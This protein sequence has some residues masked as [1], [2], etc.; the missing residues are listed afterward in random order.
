MVGLVALAAALVA[1][2]Y[3]QAARPLPL[4]A[5]LS[6]T[7]LPGSVEYYETDASSCRGCVRT[8]YP[9]TRPLGTG[10]GPLQSGSRAVPRPALIRS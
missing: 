5:T 8:T 10:A 4:G 6:S 9:P 7:V 3:G 2:A 1:P